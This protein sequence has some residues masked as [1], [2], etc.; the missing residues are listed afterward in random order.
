MTSQ[1]LQFM[2]L[3]NKK[4]VTFLYRI[5]RKINLI[6]WRILKDMIKCYFKMSV[7]EIISA[8]RVKLYCDEKSTFYKAIFK[9]GLNLYH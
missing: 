9:H 7:F 8:H 5:L 3:I 4:S 2:S 1:N 6:L